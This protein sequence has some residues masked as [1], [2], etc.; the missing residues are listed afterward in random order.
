MQRF[1]RV[2]TTASKAEDESLKRQTFTPIF[3]RLCSVVTDQYQMFASWT[4]P[5]ALAG[6]AVSQGA[7]PRSRVREGLFI[8]G[9]VINCF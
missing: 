8:T 9:N 7:L 4:H 2:P 6:N 5:M 1:V 3:H